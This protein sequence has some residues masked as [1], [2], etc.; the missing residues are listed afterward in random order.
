MASIEIEDGAELYYED[1][2]EG[3][4]LVC[5]HG[6]LCS[7]R[8]FQLQ[9]PELSRQ[10]RMVVPD[11]RG[12]GRSAS[13]PSGNLVA[14]HARD[15]RALIQSLR[16]DAVVLV[17]HSMGAFVIWD[18]IQQ[19][20]TD[21]IAATVIVDETASDFSWPDWDHGVFDLPR[22]AGTMTAIQTDYTGFARSFCSGIVLRPLPEHVASSLLDDMLSVSPAV[23]SAILFDQTIRDYRPTLGDVTVPTLLCFGGDG[24]ITPAAGRYLRDHLPDARL[25]VF[26]ESRHCPQLEE[27]DRFNTV[28]A[29]F[30]A[31]LGQ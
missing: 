7:G 26:E 25:V 6:V 9:V 29:D 18:Y 14:Q 11:L 21:G 12:H 2:G 8:F 3:R 28:L 19:F 10:F 15:L 24:A 31:S 5:L 1:Q 17:G 20:G 23:A 27:P 22:L 30:M 13:T 16:L 4:A